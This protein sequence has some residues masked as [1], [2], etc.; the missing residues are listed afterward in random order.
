MNNRSHSVKR[1]TQQNEQINEL[2]DRRRGNKGENFRASAQEH[3]STGCS[4]LA[5]SKPP[6]MKGKEGRII[7]HGCI[8]STNKEGRILTSFKP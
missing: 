6:T 5:T 3:S 2:K 8:V 1:T 4:R 7:D